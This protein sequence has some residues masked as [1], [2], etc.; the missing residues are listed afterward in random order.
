MDVLSPASLYDTEYL[1]MGVLSDAVA[2]EASQDAST[3]PAKV[4]EHFCE[5]ESQLWIKRNEND[6]LNLPRWHVLIVILPVSAS[7]YGANIL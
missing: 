3:L 5:S 4:C 6:H 2:G 1:G 7:C